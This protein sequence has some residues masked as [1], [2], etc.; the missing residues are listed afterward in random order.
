[1]NHVFLSFDKT[2]KYNF[3]YS[4]PPNSKSWTGTAEFL[5][6][7]LTAFNICNVKNPHLGQKK[8]DESRNPITTAE[9]WQLE[10]LEQF[11]EFMENWQQRSAQKMSNETHTAV[12]H[13][14]R[15][16]VLLAK[17]VRFTSVPNT[18]KSGR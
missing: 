17:Y 8:R 2:C 1:M 4:K 9:D 15:T 18:V 3:R 5:D 14:S 16:L 13:T 11:A 7:V 10:Y 6:I 12:I